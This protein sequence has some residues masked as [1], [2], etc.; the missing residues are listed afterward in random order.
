MS[1]SGDDYYIQTLNL[2]VMIIEYLL[3]DYYP[4]FTNI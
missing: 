2:Y 4:S 3:N 1:L